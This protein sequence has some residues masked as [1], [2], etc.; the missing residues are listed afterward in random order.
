VE[1]LI[2][3]LLAN[4]GEDPDREGL[5][6]TPARVTR[7]LQ[8][9]TRGYHEDPHEIARGAVF[10]ETCDEVIVVSDIE[11]YSLCEHHML[12]FWGKA[13]IAYLPDG[14]II[15]L[16]K[17]PRILDV[18]ACRLQLQERLTTQVSQ[19][20]MDILH[21][22]GVAVVIEAQHLCMMMRGVQK[23]NSKA[24]T[25]S[26]LGAFRNSPRTRAEVLQLIGQRRP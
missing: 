4:L 12:P 8:F 3:R 24:V 25:S 18:F 10:T 13:H 15:G 21:P 2:K 20:I 22:R 11:V 6:S 17:I 23:Q 7:S 16:S 1:D 14:K 26:M 9:L 19:A 5:Q